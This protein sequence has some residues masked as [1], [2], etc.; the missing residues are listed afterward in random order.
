[1][2]NNRIPKRALHHKRDG[3]ADAGRPLM[4][5]AVRETE[6]CR[7]GEDGDGDKSCQYIQMR[8]LNIG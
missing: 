2:N 5:L 1:M 8:H 3:L 7:A 6:L 4:Q